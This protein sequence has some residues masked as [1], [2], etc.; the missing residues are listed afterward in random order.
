MGS[1]RA[2]KTEKSMIQN[3]YWKQVFQSPKTKIGFIVVII[4]AV[5]AILAPVL[6]PHDPL[7]VDV[8]IKLK[9]S[10]CGISFRYGS[11]GT[12][13]FIKTSLGQPLF[14]ELQLYSTSDYRM[15][16]CADRTVCRIC[17]WKN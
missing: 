12:M 8:T 11:A 6:A 5:A 13:Y 1:R 16:W 14:T 3:L 7:L 2:Q 17:R 15:C 4:F 10:V 9:G